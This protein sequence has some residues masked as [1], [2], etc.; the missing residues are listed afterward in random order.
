[1][2]LSE[3]P[4]AVQSHWTESILKF[5]LPR[6]NEHGQPFDWMSPAGVVIYY[7]FFGSEANLQSSLLSLWLCCCNCVWGY[8]VKKVYEIIRV[9]TGNTTFF[10]WFLLSLFLHFSLQRSTTNSCADIKGQGGTKAGNKRQRE[11][12]KNEGSGK[13]FREGN[14]SNV[15]NF[16]LVVRFAF[17]I[18]KSLRWYISSS[19]LLKKKE[20]YWSQVRREE[21][22]QECFILHTF[23]FFFF[24][25]PLMMD[26]FLIFSALYNLIFWLLFILLSHF[27]VFCFVLFLFIF[28]S[29]A[30]QVLNF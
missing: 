27:S 8:S 3:V 25:P 14:K 10:C 23:F 13:V 19:S 17:L 20:R 29:N 15:C 9:K 2:A 1:M 7:I 22:M 30:T 26:S 28:L 6:Q 16:I 21:P 12:E 5:V 11:G 4:A 24:F 18:G